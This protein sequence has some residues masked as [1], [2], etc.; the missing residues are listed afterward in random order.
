[1][2]LNKFHMLIYSFILLCCLIQKASKATTYLVPLMQPDIQSAYNQSDCT[3]ILLEAGMSFT[4]ANN[5]NQFFS[6]SISIGRYGTGTNPTID[7]QNNGFFCFIF[8][9]PT[10]TVTINNLTIKNGLTM[11]PAVFAG[12]ITNLNNCVINGCTFS[13][14]TATGILGGAI[15][16]TSAIGG[17]ELTINNCTF[18]FNTSMSG[19]AIF[20][21]YSGVAVIGGD[22]TFN[23]NTADA[24]GAIYSISDNQLTINNSAFNYNGATNGNGGGL[25]TDCQTTITLCN[26]NNNTATNGGAIYSIFDS[27][28]GSPLLITNSDFNN[29]SANNGNGGGLY[30]GAGNANTIS[31]CNFIGNVITP[32]NGGA[33]YVAPN[34]QLTINSS[35]LNSNLANNGNGG[36]L[37]NDGTL[38][39]TSCNFGKDP[40]S[41]YGNYAP[42]GNG[43]ALYNN[44]HAT[45]Q[46]CSFE[47]NL[48]QSGGAICNANTINL[49]KSSFG[50]TSGNGNFATISGGALC[51]LAGTAIVST[52]NFDDNNAPVGGAIYNAF[53]SSITTTGCNFGS[54]SGN[55]ALTGGANGGAIYNNGQASFSQSTFEKNTASNGGA[56][57]NQNSIHINNC[58]FGVTTGNGA[59]YGGALYNNNAATVDTSSFQ[60]HAAPHGGAVYNSGTLT[61]L[62]STF[63]ANG[64]P[65]SSD[66]GAFLNDTNGL[67]SFQNCTFNSNNAQTGGA[68]SNKQT[69]QLIDGCTFNANSASQFA[70]ALY[71]RGQS[72][73][74]PGILALLT[75]ST[76]D[77]N[78]CPNGSGGA[79]Y[80]TYTTTTI[81]SCTFVSNSADPGFGGAICSV[82]SQDNVHCC[83]F[84][85]NT[86]SHG[87]AVAAPFGPQQRNL[88]NN[89]WGTNTDP[90]TITNL[91]TG[92]NYTYAPWMM[93]STYPVPTNPLPGQPS[94]INADF[95]MNSSG[96]PI[97]SCHIPNSVQVA[98][99]T[100][101]G[102]VT[103]PTSGTINGIAST[104]LSPI[105]LAARVCATVEPTA[106]NFTICNS[107]NTG[108]YRLN[109]GCVCT[110]VGNQHILIGSYNDLQ[111]NAIANWIYGWVFD[112]TKTTSCTA[113]TPLSLGTTFIINSAVYNYS[114][115]IYLALVA[116]TG[117]S[118]E[119]IL[120]T[121]SN[122]G[123]GYVISQQGAP[124]PLTG[125]TSASKIQWAVPNTSEP[126]NAYLAVD[127]NTGIQVY[128][129]NLNTFTF[130]S[131]I[132]TPNLAG[133]NPSAFLYWV[134]FSSSLYLVQ[135]YNQ[136]NVAT[137]LVDLTG[138][139]TIQPGVN[140]PIDGQF[141]N[142]L[143]CAT[144]NNYLVIG[145]TKSFQGT[146]VS[147]SINP[148]G[149]LNPGLAVS[150]TGTTVYR[151]E[152]CCCSDDY[153][154]VA[155]DKGLYCYTS[156]LS[157]QIASTRIPCLNCCW[158][159]N[160]K[161]LFGAA[162][163]T[164]YDSFTFEVTSSI[165]PICNPL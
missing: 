64:N 118:Y 32:G 90:G 101:Q 29:N 106:E 52:C 86:A 40:A 68:I 30:I 120:A 4:G 114:D 128:P 19:G 84:A 76:F 35:A 70:G 132:S 56:I 11:A 59:N 48:T 82:I 109:W 131:A 94:T 95:T 158:C 3:E 25:Y 20:I 66:G 77:S 41:T 36:A 47:Q 149:T 74:N 51:N 108:F 13:N 26:F 113:I 53:G 111:S 126:L 55:Y 116:W 57:N 145:G 85:L 157:T 42:S 144:C 23:N 163:K 164:N 62:N 140:S 72:V 138:T 22:C 60:L 73:A 81:M 33:I 112:V 46:N 98:F 88:Q 5:T 152:R 107:V 105:N 1:M 14:N 37:Y 124:F 65:T 61:S 44:Y 127:T 28:A 71:S 102:T 92:T 155:T 9:V 151:C 146:L 130:G 142:A 121:I 38:T 154:L 97:S 87:S 141:D 75:N 119:I 148:D 54:I 160:S 34:T 156:N 137:Y 129:V 99:N 110:D 45:L 134:P 153:L 147:Y 10:I 43:G 69:I 78:S 150:I 122:P 117:S 96:Q 17:E 104:T 21:N 162:I 89:W 80:D 139:P 2:K 143:T 58:T 123:T 93:V 63:S 136:M 39:A 125:V 103:P 79:I 15:Y 91:I 16:T 7:M 115:T 27:I 83:R 165:N 18:D 135:G 67:S 24:G 161:N 12:A 8:N 159:C 50:G 49:S 6:K 133:S 100:T 31:S